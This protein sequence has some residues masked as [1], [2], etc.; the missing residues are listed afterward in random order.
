M[1]GLNISRFVLI[2]AVSS[3]GLLIIALLLCLPDDNV[4]R[5]EFYSRVDADNMN[6]CV[7][8]KLDQVH[9]HSMLLIVTTPSTLIPGAV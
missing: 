5:V 3:R 2:L 6:H 4:L 7:L 9:Q 8:G 1:N